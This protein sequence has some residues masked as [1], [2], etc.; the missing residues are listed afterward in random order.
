[1]GVKLVDSILSVSVVPDEPQCVEA[2]GALIRGAKAFGNQDGGVIMANGGRLLALVG[3]PTQESVREAVEAAE[4]NAELV[5]CSATAPVAE[6][7]LGR[8]GEHASIYVFDGEPPSPPAPADEPKTE[9]M[10]NAQDYRLAHVP[11][12]L[13]QEIR[14]ALANGPVAAVLEDGLPV[15]FCYPAAV[16]EKYWDVSVDTL[17][18]YRRRGYATLAFRMMA[19][20]MGLR[21][22]R[23]VW[24]AV[25]SNVASNAMARRLGFV[26]SGDLFVWNLACGEQS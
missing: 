5:A 23:P 17:E 11:D 4:P 18:P 19:H 15:S 12:D 1:M 22:R 24:G 8:R 16:T 10:A 9:L 3:R 7:V 13:R 20:R 2:R 14:S 26:P 6:A 25:D 21:G